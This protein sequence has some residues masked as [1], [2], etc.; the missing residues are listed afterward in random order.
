MN[1]TLSP[2]TLFLIALALLATVD[3][4]VLTQVNANR[5]GEP[6]SVV[7][8]SERE[9]ALPFT[10][11][12]E[13]SGLSLML[14]WQT[15][16]KD[17]YSPYAG[18]W[19]PVEWLDEAKLRDLGFAAEALAAGGEHRN[20]GWE[21]L[22]REVFVVLEL[23]GPAYQLAVRRAEASVE[24]QR[25]HTG[26]RQPEGY[27]PL[28]AA[29]ERL[30]RLRA[31]ESRLFAIDAGLDPAAL[32]Q[33][34]GDRGRL[35]IARGLIEPVVPTDKNKRRVFGRITRLLV[36]RIHVPL[37]HRSVLESVATNGATDL[38][39]TGP[40]YQVDLAVGHRF[41]PW[42]VAVDRVEGRD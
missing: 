40:R 12:A 31:S 5:R 14:R 24:K 36:E 30:A 18:H 17:Q 35:L 16:A 21:K 34:Y 22:T 1:L 15:L 19:K 8:L 41:E 33:Q 7:T 20:N 2:R 6:E 27:N 11:H 37:E 28:Q 10:S 25:Q 29:E 39:K 23:D 38:Q 26:E 9:L 13:N 32:R 4:L 3:G 42:I